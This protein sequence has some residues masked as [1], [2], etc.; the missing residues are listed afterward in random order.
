MCAKK[1]DLMKT[2]LRECKIFDD[3]I[4]IKEIWVCL[5]NWILI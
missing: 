4:G 5:E 3:L 2:I 1:F